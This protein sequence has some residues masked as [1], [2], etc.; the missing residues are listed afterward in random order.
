MPASLSSVFSRGRPRS[1]EDA[2]AYFAWWA[3]QANATNH[4]LRELAADW[5]SRTA[6]FRVVGDPSPEIGLVLGGT[7]KTL[8]RMSLGAHETPIESGC[9]KVREEF[10]SA[11]AARAALWYAPM[12]DEIVEKLLPT[13]NA[14]WADGRPLA[15]SAFLEAVRPARIV[16]QDDDPSEESFTVVFSTGLFGGHRIEISCMGFRPFTARLQG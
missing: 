11:V 4:L 8:G 9:G 1:E 10:V 14:S 15:P 3:L 2:L 7:G 6:R 16:I 13:Y 5:E 12:L